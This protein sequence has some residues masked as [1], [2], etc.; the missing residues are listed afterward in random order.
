MDYDA[1]DRAM[2]RAVVRI[3]YPNGI[4]LWLAANAAETATDVPDHVKRFNRLADA[5]DAVDRNRAIFRGATLEAVSVC[6]L[7]NRT[8]VR[9]GG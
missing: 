1:I 8:P 7:F 3:T 6:D 4:I 5:W 9:T 2:S